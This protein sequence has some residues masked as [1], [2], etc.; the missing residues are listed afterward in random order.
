[1]SAVSNSER[2]NKEE[3]GVAKL[4]ALCEAS[5]PLCFLRV[6]AAI[7][8]ACTR[9]ESTD[10]L[11]PAA[12][13]LLC[14]LW[15]SS[16][17]T[18]RR[19]RAATTNLTGAGLTG[20]TGSRRLTLICSVAYVQRKDSSRGAAET[21]RRKGPLSGASL[22]GL[23]NHALGQ[24]AISAPSLS[25]QRVLRSNS[26]IADGYFHNSQITS[27]DYEKRHITF[28]HKSRVDRRGRKSFATVTM[29]VFEFMARMLYYLPDR[30][31]K[32]VRYYG[33]YA[34]SKRRGLQISPGSTWSLAIR[35]CFQ[36]DPSCVPIVARP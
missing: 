26:P 1:M 13:R 9:E 5:P 35:T 30:H 19:H 11:R 14:V 27:V 15:T 29:D 18:H 4:G 31:E 25:G 36:K 10:Y 34:Q 28:I 33:I 7:G 22:P 23:K 32:T 2:S 16:N 21:R 6:F 8:S 17:R 12:S 3:Q 20:L 24:F